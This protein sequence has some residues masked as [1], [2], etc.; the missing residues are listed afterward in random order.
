[1]REIDAALGVVRVSRAYDAE[2]VD[3]PGTPA[4]L[5]AAV[6]VVTDRDPEDLKH[7]VLRPIETR[8]GRRRT[9][10]PNAPRTID[11]DIALAGDLVLV[12]PDGEPEIPDPAIARHAHLAFPLRDLAPDVRHPTLGRSLGDIAAALE[13]AGGLA[14]RDDLDLSV[15]VRR[16]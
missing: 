15:A 5:N 9:E 3:A 1:M 4:Y 2:P 10:D 6:A 13:P 14:V 12:G 16:R 8:L 7:S 11:I